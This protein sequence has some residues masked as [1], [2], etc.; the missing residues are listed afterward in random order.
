LREAPSLLVTTPVPLCAETTGCTETRR[1]GSREGT[2]CCTGS[3]AGRAATAPSTKLS[4][5]V[6]E[7]A[8]QGAFLALSL[9]LREGNS[10]KSPDPTSR[11]SLGSCCHIQGDGFLHAHHENC[12]TACALPSLFFL[13][14]QKN[15][16]PH[17]GR[18]VPQRQCRR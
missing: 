17:G 4:S 16:V 7:G 14:P 11:F 15:T 18:T 3:R 13:S 10:S 5:A 2:A 9:L 1:A 8:G 12:T 6:R